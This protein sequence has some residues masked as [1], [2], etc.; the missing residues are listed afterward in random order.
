MVYCG[1]PSASCS[2]CRKRKTRCDKATPSCGQ[3]IRAH[4]IC[5]GYRSQL[6]LMFRN[7]S[8]T[9]KVK[10]VKSKE[11]PRAKSKSPEHSAP[12]PIAGDEACS[13]D[14]PVNEVVKYSNTPL[15]NDELCIKSMMPNYFMFPTLEERSIAL[16]GTLAPTW[17]RAFDLVENLCGQAVIEEHLQASISAVGLAG[18]SNTFRAP[19]IMAKARRDYVKALQLTNQALRSPTAAKK[20]STLFSVMVLSIYEMISGNNERSLDSWTEHIK[21]AAALIKFRGQEQF[22]SPAG[23]KLFL[24]ATANLMLS[25]I[26]RTI[27]MPEHIIQLRK[28]AEKFMDV[29]SLGWRVAGVIIDFTIFR[30]K[31]RDSEIVG[32]R[33]VVEQAL[34]LDQRFIDEFKD[35]PEEWKY[36]TLYTTENPDIVW[37]GHYHV[38]GEYWMSH[39]WNGMRTCR[40]LLHELI[41]DQLLVASTASTP[42]FSDDEN[43]VLLDSSVKIM[44]EMQADILGSVPHHT[45]SFLNQSS[46]GLLDGSRSYFVLWPLFLVGTMD[47]TTEPI[48]RWA[49]ARLRNIGETVGIRQAIVISELLTRRGLPIAWDTKPTPRLRHHQERIHAYWNTEKPGDPSGLI[50]YKDSCEMMDEFVMG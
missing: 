24:Q 33:N 21:G 39:V 26:Q 31:V 5:P 14:N 3:C 11:V 13:D 2:E 37:D 8:D 27:P 34:E 43:A 7:E 40:V 18:F 35:L 50:K 10:A 15:A 49:A 20:D 6:D 48:R 44:L 19:E 9:V 25:C 1:K 23:Q 36:M 45:P 12:N 29:D 47:L 46:S 17:F 28:E 22:K 4:R 16:F 38:Y 42:L 30:S 32:P 41:R